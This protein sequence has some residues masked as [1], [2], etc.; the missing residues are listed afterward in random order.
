[1][2]IAIYNRN[3]RVIGWLDGKVLRDISGR[4]RAFVYDNNVFT[5]SSVHLGTFQNGYIRDNRG[6]A[7]AFID[8]AKGGP[9]PPL[10]S[11]PPL[12][13]LFPLAPISPIPPVPPVAPIPSLSWSELDWDE[14][15]E[16]N[17]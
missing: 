3:G 12:A 17:Q 9:L 8:G 6:N 11:L 14:F 15:L 1:M 16:E 5:Y 4:H 10:P 2:S 7:V 13:P